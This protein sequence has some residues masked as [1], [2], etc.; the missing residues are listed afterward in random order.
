MRSIETVCSRRLRGKLTAWVGQ[1]PPRLKRRMDLC[2]MDL[3]E[4]TCPK[5]FRKNSRGDHRRRLERPI[6]GEQEKDL[7]SGFIAIGPCSLLLYTGE[8]GSHIWVWISSTTDCR[9]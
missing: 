6:I 5:T 7:Y 8:G 9:F 2:R 4:W 3:S 1:N